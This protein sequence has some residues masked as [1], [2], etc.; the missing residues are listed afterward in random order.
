MIVEKLDWTFSFQTEF[1]K[2]ER[3]VLITLP[4]PKYNDLIETY[5]PLKSI[6][7]NAR[8]TKPK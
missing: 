5:E 2:L 3:E 1:N 7:M 8:D 6:Q 4:N